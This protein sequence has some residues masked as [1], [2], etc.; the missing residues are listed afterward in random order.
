MVSPDLKKRYS[1]IS[2]HLSAYIR[3]GLLLHV[4]TL[5]ELAFVAVFASRWVC[6]RAETPESGVFGVMIFAFLVSL[7]ILSQLDARSRFQTYKR[8]KNNL[9]IYGFDTRIL[10]PFLKSRCQRNAAMAAAEELGYKR[11]CCSY[12]HSQGYR[13]YHILPDF[14]F[15]N[16]GILFS[17]QF[18][19]STFFSKTYNLNCGRTDLTD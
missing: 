7:P 1:Q 15:S 10:R 8:V 2:R 3:A 18:W 6:F 9:F 16:P 19:Q 5:L 13:W 12:Y 11:L 14:V 4:I 17:R